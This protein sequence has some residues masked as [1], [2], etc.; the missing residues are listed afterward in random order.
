M[1]RSSGDESK[2]LLDAAA[3]EGDDAVLSVLPPAMEDETAENVGG[4]DVEDRGREGVAGTEGRPS[5]DGDHDGETASG[6]RRGQPDED[7]GAVQ[8][9]ST[10]TTAKRK[11]K[12]KQQKDKK[13]K[14]KRKDKKAGEGVQEQ[15]QQQQQDGRGLDDYDKQSGEYISAEPQL[16]DEPTA[17]GS[18]VYDVPD[19][20]PPVTAI[21]GPYNRDDDEMTTGY[22]R[23]RSD[24]TRS[25]TNVRSSTICGYAWVLTLCL[26]IFGFIPW[27][28]IE[29][30][31]HNQETHVIAWFVAGVFVCLAVP[32]TIWDVAMHLKHW[33]NPMLQRHI[34]RILFM[35]PIYA[36]DSWLALRF[37]NINIYFDVARE[38]YEAY[39]IY[40]FY[41]YL[42]VFLRQRPDF[43]IDIHKREPFP[44]KFPC[45][46]LKPWRMGQPFLNACTH[47]VTSYVVV[48]LLTTIIAFASALGD[49]YGDGELAL[50]KA[51]VW[52]AIFNS[53]SQ[54]WAM[55]CLILFYYAFKPD[56]KPMRPLPKFL[57]IKAVIFFSFWQSV[58]IAILVKADV[59]KESSTWT[60]YTQ[61]SVA[62]GIQDFLVCIEMFLAAIA[63]RYVFS[64]KEHLTASD[65]GDAQLSF[66]RAVVQLLDV[67]DV[68]HTVFD[69]VQ[70][71]YTI[72]GKLAQRRTLDKTGEHTALLTGQAPS[73]LSEPAPPK[74]GEYGAVKPASNV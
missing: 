26:I 59:I 46:C 21:A 58:F 13:Q 18:A 57:T 48:R 28:A 55:Y 61:E 56:L 33:N 10:T 52:V 53:L 25:V 27:G 70:T 23:M 30:H 29:L 38:T 39:V 19:T 69:H 63:H 37:P 9:A 71:I 34:I 65:R 73:L 66:R 49:R 7:D 17:L 50:D 31:R 3:E 47:G 67:R 68:A 74:D 2:R 62:A 54:A 20:T 45:C 4:G 64:Y 32:M 51:F 35:V 11:K 14:D 24:S 41:V 5:V 43:D 42:L 15:Q 8:A 36:I 1:S 22:Q 6:S 44:H 72:D 12:K 16:Q 40:N 60:Y